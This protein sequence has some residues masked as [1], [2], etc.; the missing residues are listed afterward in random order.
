MDSLD[1]KLNAK[2]HTTE[3]ILMNLLSVGFRD[4]PDNN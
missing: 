4:K 1:L 2:I 3:E